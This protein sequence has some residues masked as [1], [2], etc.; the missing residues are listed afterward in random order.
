M[1]IANSQKNKI[2]KKY[3]IGILNETK[4]PPD[5][6]VAIPPTV[7]R[8]LVERFPNAKLLVQHSYL[9]AF[10]EDEYIEEGITIQDDLSDCDIL[11]G[12][13]EVN[14]KTFIPNKTYMFF[15]HVAKKQL[16]NRELLIDMMNKKITLIDYEYLTN[17]AGMR[18]VAFGKWA[19]IVGAYNAIRAEGIKNKYFA[20]KPAYE[21][22]NRDEMYK[23]LKDIKLRPVKIIITGGGRVAQGAMETLNAFKIKMISPNDFLTN[24]YDEAVYTKLDPWNYVKHKEN[25]EF[26]LQHFFAN[27][28]EYASTFKPYTKLADIYIPCH[29]WDPKSPIFFS[30]EEA[31]QKDFSIKIIADVSCDIAKPIPSTLRASTIAE[32]YYDY[33]PITGK[34]EP[35]FSDKNNITV[36]AVD[37]LPGELPRDASRY[38]GQKLLDNVFPN[39]FFEGE[40]EMLKN[41]TIIKDGKLTEKFAYLKDYVEGK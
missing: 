8:E 15:S 1:L 3:K 4:I 13:K 21:F 18:V 35:A 19:G 12:V 25:K 37:N 24:T 30:K 17:S 22:K 10:S 38:F 34:E 7:G 20:I 36:M 33:N 28:N 16:Y 32:P 39:L 29:F 41:A 40:N 2:M 31:K 23:A 26:D 9:R 14:M 6:R 27:P 5:R 11:I